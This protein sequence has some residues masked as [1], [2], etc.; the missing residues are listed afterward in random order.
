MHTNTQKTINTL[1]AVIA[2][3]QKILATL[4]SEDVEKPVKAVEAEVTVTEVKPTGENQNRVLAAWLRANGKQANGD[5]WAQAKALVKSGLTPE[6]AV[7]AMVNGA[8]TTPVTVSPSKTASKATSAK[9]STKKARAAKAAK[10]KAEHPVVECKS[11]DCSNTFERKS[12][13]HEYCKSCG[14]KRS[15]GFVEF[16]TARAQAREAA[17]K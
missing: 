11:E 9:P 6:D 16:L 2:D 8:V 15:N 13:R 17:A 10:P 4:T 12:S 14:E 7:K 3:A 5:D 1:N